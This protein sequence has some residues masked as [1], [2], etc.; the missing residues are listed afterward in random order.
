MRFSSTLFVCF[1]LILGGCQRV[2]SAKT[3]TVE[4]GVVKAPFIIDPPDREKTVTVTVQPEAGTPVDVY[5]I[6]GKDFDAVSN[7]MQAGKEP[8]NP[9]GGR[10]Q[11]DKEAVITA[12]VPAKNEYAVVVGNA[13]KT[14]KV[15]LKLDAR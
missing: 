4:A 13:K 9:L 8:K 12:K 11:I 2:S 15:T 10:K 6:L 7:D 14:T 3:E 5:V 1:A